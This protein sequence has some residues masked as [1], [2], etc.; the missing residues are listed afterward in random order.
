MIGMKLAHATR[1]Q[2]RFAITAGV[3]L[4][5]LLGSACEPVA[6]RPAYHVSS[7][8]GVVEITPGARPVTS[9]NGL[10]QPES[11]R[12]DPEQDVFFV[13]NMDG[14]GSVKDGAG[15]IVRVAAGDYARADVFVASGVAG[16]VLNAPKGLAIRD[17]TLWVADIDVL[18]GFHR[19]TGKPLVTIDFRP[20][21]A[22]MLN[23]IA[24]GPD[25]DLYVTDTGIRM[26]K[27][28]TIYEGGEQI[29]AVTPDLR[30]RVLARGSDL[31]F[32]N[33]VAW[34]STGKRLVVATFD[35]F[36]SHIYSVATAANGSTTRQLLA[37]GPGKFDGIEVLADGSFIV[38]CWDDYSIH[39]IKGAEHKR[40]ATN[41][42]QPADLGI[43]TRRNLLLVPSVL[44]GRVEVWALDLDDAARR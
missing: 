2:T 7:L 17:S 28:G 20:Y 1:M 39:W 27:A 9:V 16:A 11:V 22:L 18:R 14:L 8:G 12:Y 43:D 30:V 3:A 29:F 10:R 42:Y 44:L 33:G 4:A 41:V 38:S 25:G 19:V 24:V 34:D 13:S 23:D 15:Y 32:P 6:G 31:R 35:A 26:V 5:G 40:I 36:E 37:K 21:D